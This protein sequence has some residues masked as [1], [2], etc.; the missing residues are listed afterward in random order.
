MEMHSPEGT[1]WRFDAGALFLEFML[2]GGPDKIARYD[3]L[4]E[5]T[6][7]GR[8][9]RD[10][11]LGIEP[12]SIGYTPRDIPAARSLRDALWRLTW[13]SMS[14]EPGDPAD[15]RQVNL[16]AAAAPLAPEIGPDLQSRWR[17]PVS[18]SAVLSTVARDAIEVLTGPAAVRIREC[19]AGDCQLVFLDT[20]RPGSRRWCSMERC[21]NRHKVRAIRSRRS[22]STAGGS[23]ALTEQ[24][25]PV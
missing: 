24:K 6:D 10:S 16:A 21:G 23:T 14:A 4:H 18:A 12:E 8:W 19:E 1:R 22:T 2:T 5:T 3:S 11:R 15:L 9:A 7:L 17:L 13:S 25:G 20:S